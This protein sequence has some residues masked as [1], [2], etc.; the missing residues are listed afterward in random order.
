MLVR[1]LAALLTLLYARH[2]DLSRGKAEK[3]L[4]KSGDTSEAA[5]ARGIHAAL[6]SNYEVAETLLKEADRK[7]QEKAK[8]ML[9]RLEEVRKSLE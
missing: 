5:Y 3:Y 8:E 1:L 9:K 6:S 4:E 7:G 2:N